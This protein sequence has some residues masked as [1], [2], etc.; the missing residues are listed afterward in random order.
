MCRPP[1]VGGVDD[2]PEQ[3]FC[4]LNE[5]CIAKGKC[6]FS[7]FANVAAIVINASK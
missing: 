5:S 6:F 2:T 1:S 3:M 4:D 7:L